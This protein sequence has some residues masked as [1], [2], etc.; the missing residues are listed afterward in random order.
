M[1]NRQESLDISAGR[2]PGLGGHAAA[3]QYAVPD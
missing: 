1:F 3:G 2:F